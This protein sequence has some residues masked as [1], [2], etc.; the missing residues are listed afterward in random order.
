MI[1]FKTNLI[2]AETYSENLFKNHKSIY[3]MFGYF[4]PGCATYI[5]E[6]PVKS[7]LK[8]EFQV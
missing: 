8:F 4:L 7:V 3:L 1:F 5:K 2:E 6:K